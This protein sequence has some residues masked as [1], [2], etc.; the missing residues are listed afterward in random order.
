MNIESTRQLIMCTNHNKMRR[1][2]NLVQVWLE[3][4]VVRKLNIKAV[5]VADI[6][7]DAAYSSIRVQRLRSG[8]NISENLGG[9]REALQTDMSEAMVDENGTLT[10]GQPSQVACAPSR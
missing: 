7:R 5:V 9:W 4:G 2:S 3:V 6:C 1:V 8:V 10:S